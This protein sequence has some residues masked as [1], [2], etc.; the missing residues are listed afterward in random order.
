VPRGVG[1]GVVVV[2]E[3]EEEE[4]EELFYVGCNFIEDRLRK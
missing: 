4:E 2:E 3:E 1:D